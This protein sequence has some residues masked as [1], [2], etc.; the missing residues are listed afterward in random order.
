VKPHRRLI[1]KESAAFIFRTE[2]STFRTLVTPTHTARCSHQGAA[3]CIFSRGNFTCKV[4][5]TLDS[6]KGSW[7]QS[8]IKW[9]CHV[10][11]VCVTN[12]NGFWIGWLDL[13]ALLYKHNQLQQLTIND[14]PRLAPF[15]TGLRVSS[16]PLTT[17]L[18]MNNWTPLCRMIELSWNE[19]TSRRPEYR[20]PPRTVR[21]IPFFRFHETCLQNCCP[22]MN[23][24]MSIRC[25]GN[26][27]LARCW[28]AVDLR[29]GSTIPAVRR[30]VTIENTHC[31]Y[32]Y[33]YCDM[34]TRCWIT[35]QS[36]ARWP[37][38][39]RLSTEHTLRSS[40][41]SGVCSVPF[42]A[43]EG[44]ERAAITSRAARSLQR[45]RRCKHGDDATELTGSVFLIAGS[46][47]I[48]EAVSS[49]SSV[50]RKQLYERVRK[51]QSYESVV[52]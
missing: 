9:Y 44:E 38:A 32:S 28:L 45:Q 6:F 12:N 41:R 15:L 16:L 34:S 20:S 30:H 2:V 4:K 46:G 29:S 47:Y 39:K 5:I 33:V 11:G 49:F 21:I 27:C 8:K 36:F 42:R 3:I 52:K 40:K 7:R 10:Q 51:E 17:V 43:A 35:Q 37:T 48:S 19:L 22:A 18:R 50:F 14:C 1:W 31:M 24:S 26:V 25:S 23:Y 13:L